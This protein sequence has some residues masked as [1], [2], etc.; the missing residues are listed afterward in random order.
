MCAILQ[1]RGRV[2]RVVED[3]R[4]ADR[5][6]IADSRGIRVIYFLRCAINANV[7]DGRRMGYFDE[8]RLGLLREIT[9]NNERYI[10]N[11]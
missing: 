2:Q 5:L 6:T 3:I 9:I 11:I 7:I 10:V 4:V 1:R 8:K